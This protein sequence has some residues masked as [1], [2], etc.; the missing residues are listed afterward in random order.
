[1]PTTRYSITADLTWM[2]PT[3]SAPAMGFLPRGGF[4][5][6]REGIR[7]Q[8]LS[9][10]AVSAGRG[11]SRWRGEGRR[12]ASVYRLPLTRRPSFLRRFQFAPTEPTP[13]G[14]ESLSDTEAP[15][16]HQ[17]FLSRGIPVYEQLLNLDRLFGRERMFFV[18][19]PLK[20]SD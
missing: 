19:V 14:V 2:R 8:L 4:A 16:I 11:F 6:S 1:M 12:C 13:F 7:C 15:W 9:A 20:I 10:R 5:V 3:T 17:S 18:G